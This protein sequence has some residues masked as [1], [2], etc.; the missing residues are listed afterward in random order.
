MIHDNSTLNIFKQNH[1]SLIAHLVVHYTQSSF[2]FFWYHLF[3]TIKRVPEPVYDV[4]LDE[5]NSIPWWCKK[6]SQKADVVQLGR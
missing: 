4:R 5:R 6:L 2:L 3:F 1:E